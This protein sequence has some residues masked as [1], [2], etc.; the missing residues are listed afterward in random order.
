MVLT[1]V[2]CAYVLKALVCFLL[3]AAAMRSLQRVSPERRWEFV[4]PGVGFLLVAG[5]LSYSLWRSA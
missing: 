2:G 1:I 4:V 3:P 5:L